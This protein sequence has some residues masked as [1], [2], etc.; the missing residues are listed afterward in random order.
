[1]P[2][3]DLYRAEFYMPEAG[4]VYLILREADKLR[5]FYWLQQSPFGS[6]Q[7]GHAARFEWST[8]KVI[9]YLN[10]SERHQLVLDD[11]G[12]VARV[13]KAEADQSDRVLPVALYVNQPPHQADAYAFAFR[14]NGPVKLTFDVFP[15]KGG[16]AAAPRQEFPSA[17][18]GKAQWVRFDAAKWADGWYRMKVGGNALSG[19]GGAVKQEVVFYHTRRLEN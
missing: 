2:V 6:W 19:D 14:P 5:Y 13:G 7:P 9:R 1:V 12:A 8:V 3:P 17:V 16:A 4:M 15:E 18:A 10:G 11:L